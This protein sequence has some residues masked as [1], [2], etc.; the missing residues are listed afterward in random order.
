VALGKDAMAD[1]EDDDADA[2]AEPVDLEH[3]AA[4]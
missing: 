2:A 4:E 1:A 3:A